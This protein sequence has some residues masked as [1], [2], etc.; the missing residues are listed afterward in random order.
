MTR[1]NILRRAPLLTALCALAFVCPDRARAQGAPFKSGVDMVALTVAVSDAAG[2]SVTGLTADDF[3]VYEDGVQQTLSLFGSEQVPVDVALVLDTS[4]SMGID[5]PLV[6]AAARGLVS[7]LRVGDRAAVVDVKQTIRLPRP[8]TDDRGQVF[9]ALDALR[10]RGS[11]ALYDGLY[12]SLREFER[13]RRQG[14]DLRRQALVLLSD[15]LD[16]ASHVTFDDVADLAR[17][18]DL[19]IYTI[20]LRGAVASAPISQQDVVR[21]ADYAIRALARETGGL[22]FFPAKAAELEA[23]YGTIARELVTQYAL[24]YVASTPGNAAA[25][26]RITVRV[27]PPG[28]GT[29]RTR[30]GYAALR[31]TLAADGDAAGELRRRP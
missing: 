31:P 10:A 26:R 4:S 7:R 12:T 5:L 17:R 16:N 11:T 29:A 1:T 20:A 19:T 22:A 21:K 3:A 25:F 18:L 15:G 27:L 14:A 24:G 13:E 9:T 6:K 8:F 30:S 2:H 28:K 23:I